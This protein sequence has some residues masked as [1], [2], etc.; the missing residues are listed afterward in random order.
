MGL[1][2][3]FACIG[4]SNDEPAITHSSAFAHDSVFLG[5]F[6]LPRFDETSYERDN[7][8]EYEGRHA[9]PKS[10]RLYLLLRKVQ[11]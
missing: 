4:A 10:V 8:K 7:E 2:E 9:P 1:W 3:Q 11:E 5:L 6:D